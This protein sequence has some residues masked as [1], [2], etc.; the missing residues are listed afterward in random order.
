MAAELRSFL[1]SEKQPT[2]NQLWEAARKRALNILT[3]LS[4]D[5]PALAAEVEKS[6][7]VSGDVMIGADLF[8]L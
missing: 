3:L 2:R 5:N 6:E 8:Q 1:R 4:A 7:R